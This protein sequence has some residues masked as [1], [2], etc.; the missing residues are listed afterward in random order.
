VTPGISSFAQDPRG[1]IESVRPLIN[2]AKSKVPTH[3]TLLYLRA[4]AGM[5]LLSPPEQKKILKTLRI[6]FKSTG[7][8]FRDEWADIISGQ[9][10]GGLG[11]VAVNYLNSTL[12]GSENKTLGALDL[13]GA[14]TQ[15][16]FAFQNGNYGNDSMQVT[17]TDDVQYQ[18]YSKSY[19]GLGVDQT[20]QNMIRLVAKPT[21]QT[22][23]LAFPCFPQAYNENFTVSGRNY[24]IVGTSDF[25]G[26]RKLNLNFLRGWPDSPMNN[27]KLPEIPKRKTFT[28]F[29]AFFY[30]YQ[31]FNLT[32]QAT[33]NDIYDAAEVFC[34]LDYKDQMRYSNN[35]RFAN[36]FCLYAVHTYGLLVDGYKF[37]PLSQ[38]QI[39]PSATINNI[40]IGW[41]PGAMV[42]EATSYYNNATYSVLNDFLEQ[43]RKRRM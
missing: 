17:F 31:F 5:R 39:K 12:G 36:R 10:E 37:D 7:F 19:L 33:L 42:Y 41:A 23:T 29:S 38:V 4:T 35:N 20:L 40:E 3:G 43:L 24:N 13:G 30:T 11:W 28:A 2:Y 9:E 8:T 16:S 22:T 18:L 34:A 25:A 26:C 6:Y 32:D 27:P 1:L 14:S 21:L 15:I